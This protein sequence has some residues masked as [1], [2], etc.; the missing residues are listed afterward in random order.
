MKSFK[1]N[2]IVLLLLVSCVGWSQQKQEGQKDDETDFWKNVRFGGGIQLGIGNGYTAIGVSPSAIY[3]FSDK[4][5]AG[6][7][8]SYLYS[9]YKLQ[10]LTYNVY[11]ASALVLYNPIK[12][13]QFSS[14]FEEL[15]V[16]QNNDGIKDSYL[17]PA[18]Y[19][20]AAYSMG[21]HAAIGIRYD[22]LFDEDK[23]I[24]DSAF[25]PFIRVY[26]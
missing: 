20:G 24:Y 16:M 10:N 17:L 26:F 6:I 2:T 25:T 9:K 11:G 8:I 19:M 23:S 12:E 3:E 13:F 22:V 15:N 18:W 4:F 1:Y 21:R 14:E 7:G 5:A